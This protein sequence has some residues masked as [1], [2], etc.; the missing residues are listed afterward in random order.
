MKSPNIWDH[1]AT[2]ELENRVVAAD[3]ALDQAL[4]ALVSWADRDVP[5]NARVTNLLLVAILVLF[6]F[7]GAQE[8]MAA[9]RR[10]MS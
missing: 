1:P 7:V 10:I 2:Y 3:G 4:S 5:K 8:A 9:V 6:L